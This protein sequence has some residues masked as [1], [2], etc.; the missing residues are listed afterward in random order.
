M[1]HD[2]GWTNFPFDWLVDPDHAIF[3]VVIA[4]VWQSSG[5]VMALFL[6]GLRGVDD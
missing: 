1:L 5:F 2:W 3:C 4:A 6:A